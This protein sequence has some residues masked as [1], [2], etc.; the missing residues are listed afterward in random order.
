M[1]GGRP[2]AYPVRR[3]NGK[4]G[5]ARG[6]GV[7]ATMMSEHQRHTDFLRHCLLY[8][9]SSERDHREQQIAQ[10]QRD[11][12]CVRSAAW[13]MG[14]LLGMVVMSLFYATVLMDNFPYSTS[15]II[16]NFISALGITS[17]VS[18]LTFA[19]L[20]MFYRRKL[21]QQRDECRQ[22]VAKLLESRL[23]NPVSTPLG[24]PRGDRVGRENDR[25]NQADDEVIASLEKIESAAQG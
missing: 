22:L 24:D 11:L 21:D 6:E 23:G 15:Q 10:I 12:R 9:D 14:T 3:T 4:N 25:T 2:T 8:A 17:L 19:G 18:L 7:A 16:V 13:L 5:R 20:G 1:A